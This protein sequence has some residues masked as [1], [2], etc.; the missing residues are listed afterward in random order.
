MRV[1][2]SLFPGFH[3]NFAKK[4]PEDLVWDKP[5]YIKGLFTSAMIEDG[6]DK[7]SI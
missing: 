5:N 3:L 1:K 7:S 6:R 2:E 4:M